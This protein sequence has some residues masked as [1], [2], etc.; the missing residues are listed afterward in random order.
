MRMIESILADAAAIAAVR[1]DIHAHPE[2]CFEEQ[3]TSD[4]IARQLTDWD[5]PIHRGMGTTGVVAILTGDDLATSTRPV[6]AVLSGSNYKETGW[7]AMAVG[8]T[9]FVGELIAAVVATDRYAAEDAIDAIEVTYETL[10]VVADVEAAMRADAPRIH[11]EIADNVYLHAHYEKG[12]VQKLLD[13]C[14]I[15]LKETMRQARTTSAPMEARATMAM[16]DPVDGT[17]TVWA[18][19]QSP[20]MLRTGLAEALGVPDSRIR[21]LRMDNQEYIAISGCAV[22]DCVAHR[23]P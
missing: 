7:P 9:R 15:R 10:P 23:G 13:G 4:L 21:M 1:R 17:L 18:S 2:L 20:H 22:R 11:E 8:K 19:S 14:E 3:R 16:V 6:R 12:D 5:I